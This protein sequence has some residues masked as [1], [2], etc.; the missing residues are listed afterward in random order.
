[1]VTI[2]DPFNLS[3]DPLIFVGRVQCTHSNNFQN[4]S[5]GFLYTPP[6]FVCGGYNET[7]GGV[8]TKPTGHHIILTKYKVAHLMAVSENYSSSGILILLIKV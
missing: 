5:L 4:E 6:N 8:V 7:G 1:M 3:S 2:F